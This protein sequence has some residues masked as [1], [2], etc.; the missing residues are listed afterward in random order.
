[1]KK[2]YYA[3]I[4]L[5]FVLLALFFVFGKKEELPYEYAFAKR[6]DIKQIVSVTG[7]VKPKKSI[8]LGFEVSGIILKINSN[9]DFVK[10]GDVLAVL[11]L[12]EIDKKIEQARAKIEAEQKALKS[13]EAALSAEISRLEEMEKGTREEEIKIAETEVKN[14][15]INL[16][17]AKA[18]LENIKQKAEIDTTN[19]YNDIDDILNDAYTKTNDA[20]NNKIA[21]LFS[22]FNPNDFKLTFEVLDQSLKFKAQNERLSSELLLANIKDIL[23][24]LD[25]SDRDLAKNSLSLALGNLKQIRDF[26]NILSD[27]VDVSFGLSLSEKETFKNNVD[28]AWTE[29]NSLIAKIDNQIQAI[30]LQESINQNNISQAEAKVNSAKNN[31]AFAKDN[32]ALKKAGF[33]EEQIEAQR[34]KVVQA[35]SNVGQQKAILK[36]AESELKRLEI[37]REKRILKAPIDGE[38]SWEEIE[39]GEFV[40]FGKKIVSISSKDL[41]EIE[42]YIPEADITKIK[43]GQKAKVTLDAYGEDVVFEAKVS[44]ISSSETILEG[45][46]TYKVK[47]LFEGI[48]K[49]VNSGMTANLDIIT[50]S[51]NDV[52]FVPKRAVYDKEGKKFVKVVQNGK[53]FEKEVSV[54]IK[55]IGVVEIIDGL[56]EGDKVVVLFK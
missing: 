32:L 30:N 51:K 55:G 2:V 15:Q 38:A 35:E 10:K 8:D 24:N 49:K 27:A 19:L 23:S 20:L 5:V 13:A 53:I 52:I 36:Q 46:S 26:L 11:N 44:K 43:K 28:L 47:F 4:F 21:S 45:V 14:A 17:D 48:D 39:A 42:A 34:Q 33:S 54:G 37:E 18:N 41:Y 40:S 29:V 25:V 22:E 50:Q 7:N 31:L 12:N 6:G 16:D 9:K 1:M 56:S 3:T